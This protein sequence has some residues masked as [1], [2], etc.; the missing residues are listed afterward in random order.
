M[1]PITVVLV[2]SAAIQLALTLPVFR[3]IASSG[4]R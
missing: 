1:G 4:A 2:A 3:A